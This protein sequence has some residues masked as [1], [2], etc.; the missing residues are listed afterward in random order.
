MTLPDSIK[1]PFGKV[2][3]V[4]V[5]GRP[6]VGKS[7]FINCVLG[8]HL[9]A[10]SSVP[11]TTRRNCLGIYS[12]ETLQIIFLD[13]PG[14]HLGNTKLSA[15]MSKSVQRSL[16]DPDLVL[17]LCDPTRKNG[18]EDR[19]VIDYVTNSGKYTIFALNKS[20]KSTPRQ[21][22]KAIGYYNGVVAGP[23]QIFN[24]S[25]LTGE[26][27]DK[28]LSAITESLP[29]GPFLYPKD[30]LSE[31]VERDIAAD[32]IRESVNKHLFDEIPHAVVIEI[33]SWKDHGKKIKISANLHVEKAS[34]KLIVIGKNGSKLN[35]IKRDAISVLRE[36]FDQY[37]SLTIFV[38][39]SPD[40]FNKAG[41]LRDLG[42]G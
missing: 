1:W 42:L 26:N 14:V 24:I 19:L 41:F 16:V 35:Q 21:R 11:Q 13:T 37:I 2:G 32:L 30:Q 31:A 39:V 23:S 12:D 8:C 36:F 6:N 18:E 10:V 3:I 7:T 5:V 15:N 40:W 9:H 29:A 25:A 27:V 38:R 17:C 4:A 33:L 28:L 22:E 20:D 34:Q